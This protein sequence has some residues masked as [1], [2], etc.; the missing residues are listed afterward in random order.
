[1]TNDWIIVAEWIVSKKDEQ[2]EHIGRFISN[3]SA[4]IVHSSSST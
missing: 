1:M 4:K 2:S 3:L